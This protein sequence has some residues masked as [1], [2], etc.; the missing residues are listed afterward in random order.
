MS[1]RFSLR[2]FQQ[3]VLDRLKAQ[4][5]SNEQ[6]S[7]LGVQ[8]GSEHWLVDMADISEVMSLPKLTNVPHTKPWYCG[9]SNVRGTLYSVIDLA[10]FEGG[11]TT[12]HE[13]LS[14]ILLIGAKY[15]FNAALLVTRI[16]GLRNS[17]SWTQ[18]EHGSEKRYRDSEGVEW[19]V[20][21]IAALLQRPEFLQIGL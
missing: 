17:S 15:S 18:L 16:L 8:I 6:L 2:E 10:Q 20:L 9:I 1:T 19:R 12:P 5:T 21:D 11:A 7:I 4:T 13:G 3:G 14:R